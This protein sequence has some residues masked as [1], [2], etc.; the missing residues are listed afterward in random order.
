MRNSHNTAQRFLESLEGLSREDECSLD[1]LIT[2]MEDLE[3]KNDPDPIEIKLLDN[4][5]NFTEKFRIL[6][7]N[8]KS[9]VKNSRKNLIGNKISSLI[10]DSSKLDLFFK[11]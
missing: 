3:T 11:D 10:E 2:L 1:I 4:I 7:N 8:I 5:Y 9:Y 6:E